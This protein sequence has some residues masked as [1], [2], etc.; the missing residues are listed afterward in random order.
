MKLFPNAK[1]NIGLNVVERRTDGYHNIETVFYPVDLQD[2]IEII[3]AATLDAEYSFSTSGIKIDGDAD[4]NL[5]IKAFRLLKK[6]YPLPATNIHLEKNIPFGAGLGG[7]SADAAFVL[8]GLNVLY[9]LQLS[10]EKLEQ[11]ATKLGADCAFFIQNK[12]VF[13]SGTGNEF[14]PVNLSLKGY[15]LLLAKPEIHVSTP[16]AYAMLTPSKPEKSLLESL[17]QPIE[18]WKTLITNDFEKAVFARHPQIGNIKQQMYDAGALYAAMSGSGSAVF[19][20]FDALPH[21]PAEFEQYF[22]ATIKL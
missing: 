9:N 20:I 17:Q 12:A 6:D 2:V 3:P 21:C 18:K 4:N 19:G 11:Y 1:I 13:A 7:G 22:T 16:E 15:Y 8:K 14:T 5:I 10:D